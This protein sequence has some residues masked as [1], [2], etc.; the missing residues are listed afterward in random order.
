M[1]FDEAEWL[2]AKGQHADAAALYRELAEQGDRRAQTRLAWMLEAGRGVPRDLQEAAQRFEA[3]AQA[4]EAE[5][6]YALAVMMR[7][8]KGRDK[9]LVASSVWLQ[10]AADQHYPAAVA[11]LQS[12][13]LVEQEKTR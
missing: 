3:A 2:G 13:R 10:R 8:G 9:D 6:Q 7:T 11:A 4:G 5:A 12:D 1:P